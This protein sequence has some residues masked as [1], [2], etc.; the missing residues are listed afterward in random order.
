V[1]GPL[2]GTDM[3]KVWQADDALLD[4]IRDREVIGCV[5]ADVA[6]DTVATANEAATGKVK[7]GI[8]RDCL[9]GENGRTKV[10]GW[11]PKWMA[12]PP[13]AYTERGGVPA[14]AR[15]AKVASLAI[16]PEP[17]PLRAAA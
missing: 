5:L 13:A 14:V 3:A 7:R 4:L 8:V 6:G 16:T 10:E 17:L 2:L 9:T 15:A 12:F 11:V 1:L